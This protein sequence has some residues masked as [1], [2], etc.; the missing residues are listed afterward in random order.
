MSVESLKYI[1][2]DFVIDGSR[3]RLDDPDYV[4]NHIDKRART[5]IRKG[6]RES[7]NILP[8][9]PTDQTAFKTLQALTPNDDDIPPIFSERYFGFVAR[10][11]NDNEILGWI[12]LVDEIDHLFM[13]CHASTLAGKQLQTPNLLLWHAIQNFSGGKYKYLNVGASYRPS[14]QAFFSQWRTETYPIILKPPELAPDFRLTPF[15][16]QKLTTTLAEPAEF[17]QVEALLCTKFNNRPYTFFPRATF[18]IKSLISWLAEKNNWDAAA[19]VYVATTTGSPYVSGCVTSAIEHTCPIERDLSE[20]TK[21]IFVIHEFGVP[22]AALTDLARVAKERN[23]PLIEDCAYAWFSPGCGQLGDYVIYSSTKPFATQFGGWLV[24]ESFSHEQLWNRFACDDGGKQLHT[25]AALLNELPKTEE[26]KQQRLQNAAYYN[27][28]FGLEN[29]F[30]NWDEDVVPGAYILR[31]TDAEQMQK[32]STF[33]R[34]F[35]IECG[36]YWHNNAITL[37]VHQNIN[38]D[39]RRYIAGAVLANFRESCGIPH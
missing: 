27:Q 20:N 4:W 2:K 22:C 15:N 11:A 39:A 25:Y 13:L 8:F 9:D 37:P 19:R 6:Q 34:S 14:L 38:L 3:I 12:L 28:I 23:I 30:F 10:R 1:S 16:N 17:Q 29:S 33:V 21:A 31:V 24:G 35:G 7:V 26:Y 32:I 18:A 36:N 5:S